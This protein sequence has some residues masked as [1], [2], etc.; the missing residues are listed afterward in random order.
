MAQSEEK[1][2]Y[3]ISEDFAV[4]EE[5][6]AS[7][8][9]DQAFK[10]LGKLY[11]KA[12]D[13]IGKINRTFNPTKKEEKKMKN[14]LRRVLDKIL[15]EEDF[16]LTDEF[17]AVSLALDIDGEELLGIWKDKNNI[18]LDEII[19]AKQRMYQMLI[20]KPNGQLMFYLG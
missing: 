14:S 4:F 16:F 1:D 11:K 7:K 20:E 13:I 10:D 12:N 5:Y 8:I 3:L 2:V 15:Y 19:P 17:N 18:R 6:L 9:I